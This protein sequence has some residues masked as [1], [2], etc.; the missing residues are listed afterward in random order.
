MKHD[1]SPS[2]SW[3]MFRNGLGFA[4]ATTSRARLLFGGAGVDTSPSR[5]GPPRAP[6]D[7]VAVP[8]VGAATAL[9]IALLP[10]AAGSPIGVDMF[11][12]LAERLGTFAAEAESSSAL[13]APRVG[14]F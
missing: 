13:L 11:S 1:P 14:T 4:V 6:K 3:T 7:G 8:V 10:S 2:P 5:E 9:P 12:P